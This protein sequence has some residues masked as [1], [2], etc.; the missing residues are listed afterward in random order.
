MTRGL[1][2]IFFDDGLTATCS[3]ATIR[4]PSAVWR[5]MAWHAASWSLEHIN[6][7]GGEQCRAEN[8]D[9]NTPEALVPK[10]PQ[11]STAPSRSAV[12]AP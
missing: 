5:P 12:G 11:G 1:N 4:L 6:P 9:R 7:T 2:V 10:Q 3:A 8:A